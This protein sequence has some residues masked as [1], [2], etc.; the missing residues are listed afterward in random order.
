MS[1]AYMLGRDAHDRDE[2]LDMNPYDDKDA[3]FD[4]WR[5]GWMDAYVD[6]K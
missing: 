1:D 6:T 2:D 4:E 3:Q 5:Y